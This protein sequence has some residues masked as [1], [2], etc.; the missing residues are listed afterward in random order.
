M[1]AAIHCAKIS[2]LGLRSTLVMALSFHNLDPIWIYS[3]IEGKGSMNK[4]KREWSDK[5][6]REWH[7]LIKIYQGLP[8]DLCKSVLT[9]YLK[10]SIVDNLTISLRKALTVEGIIDH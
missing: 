7:D 2:C 6:K 8:A 3:D 9:K 5:D 1:P 10:F 4:D